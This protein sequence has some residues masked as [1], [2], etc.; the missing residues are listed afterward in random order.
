MLPF[1]AQSTNAYS[2][3]SVIIPVLMAFAPSKA[4]IAENAQH[5][6]HCP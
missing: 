6:P 2:E 3:N 1:F 5:D 4:P